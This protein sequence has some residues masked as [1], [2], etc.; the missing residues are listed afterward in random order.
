MASDKERNSSENVAFFY[1]YLTAKHR[2]VF[3]GENRGEKNENV[4]LVIYIVIQ[5]GNN[6]LL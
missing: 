2:F 1:F 4:V 3:F 6:V 5:L